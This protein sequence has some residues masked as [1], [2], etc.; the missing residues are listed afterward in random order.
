[1]EEKFYFSRKFFRQYLIDLMV[2]AAIAIAT[3]AV[4]IVAKILSDI[5]TEKS[6]SFIHA[7]VFIFIVGG[8]I[9]GGI[10]VGSLRFRNKT[11]ITITDGKMIFEPSSFQNLFRN[12]CRFELAFEQIISASIKE[13]QIRSITFSWGKRI[14]LRFREGDNKERVMHLYLD[15]IENHARLVD[16]LKQ[17]IKFV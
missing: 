4:F 9:G 16:I 7:V 6:A 2:R 14:E 15:R 1:M 13:S 3:S 12:I 5:P 17:R 11:A 10:L 8:I